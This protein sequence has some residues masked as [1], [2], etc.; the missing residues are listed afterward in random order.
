VIA[1]YRLSRGGMGRGWLPE[2]GGTNNQPAWLIAAFAILAA[3][4]D[5]IERAM[6]AVQ[7]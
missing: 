2:A 6:K 5:R 4:E 3:E 1:A 7:A